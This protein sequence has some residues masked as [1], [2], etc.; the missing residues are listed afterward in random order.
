MNPLGPPSIAIAF[1]K[2]QEDNPT[3]Q[4]QQPQPQPQPQPQGNDEADGGG[5]DDEDEDVAGVSVRGR[6]RGRGGR[7]GGRAGRQWQ[8]TRGEAEYLKGWNKQVQ[9]TSQE[10]RK[11]S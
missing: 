8:V 7:G 9:R 6:G 1:A 5:D 4:Q 3:T 2:F 10:I 11:C